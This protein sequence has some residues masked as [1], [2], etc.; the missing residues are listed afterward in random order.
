MSPRGRKV[1]TDPA[2]TAI[3]EQMA[4]LVADGPRAVALRDEFGT[5]DKD[6][7]ATVGATIRKNWRSVQ[8][9]AKCRIDYHPTE[10]YPQVR[11]KD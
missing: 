3:F 1:Q 10:G 4:P 9:D 7:R 2:L 8:G 11:V 5:V 6:S